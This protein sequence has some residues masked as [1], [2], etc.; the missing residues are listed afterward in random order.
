[1]KHPSLCAALAPIALVP[2]LAFPEAGRAGPHVC[3][4]C[5]DRSTPEPVVTIFAGPRRHDHECGSTEKREQA[6]HRARRIA[7]VHPSLIAQA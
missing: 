6:G 2:L 4:P 1:M 7:S 5:P 3:P